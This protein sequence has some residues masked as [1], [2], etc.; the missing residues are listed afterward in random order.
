MR[1]F[2]RLCRSVVV[3]LAACTP[4][5]ACALSGGP[6]EGQVIDE[7]TRKPIVGAVVVARWQGHLASF[8]HGKTVCYHVLSTT[9]DRMGR[10]RFAAWKE[11]VTEDWQK[12]IR[13]EDVL[14]VAYKSGFEW[15]GVFS[16]RGD[17][18]YLKPFTGGRE[19]RFKYLDRV[20]S[21]TS[22]GSARTSYKN[23]YPI[24]LAVYQEAKAIAHSGSEMK[25][26]ESFKEL[27]EDTLVDRTKPTKYD[28]RGRLINVD[29]RDT[30]RAEDLK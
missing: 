20:V 10:Y 21:G 9:T 26:A 6:I 29:P 27:A 18:Q 13:Q 28:E 14:I 19:E 16:E 22:C 12:N 2:I 15:S 30:F 17:V 25:R 11:D 23:L 7:R 4:L 5:I 1:I 24:R 8:A 3:V